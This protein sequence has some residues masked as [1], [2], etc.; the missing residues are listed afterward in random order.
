MGFALAEVANELGAKVTIISG[1]VAIQ[2]HNPNINRIDVISADEMFKVTSENAENQDILIFS[3]AVADYTPKTK[4]EGKL[5]KEY[6]HLD[7]IE[8][9]ET[10]DI[11]KAIAS[12]K[13]ANQTIVGFALESQDLENNA[14]KKLTTKNADYIIA[15]YANKENSGFGGELNTIKIFSKDNSPI[16]LPTMSKYNCALMIFKSIIKK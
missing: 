9:I 15:N 7:K 3:A 14:Q 6:S 10:I 12:Q 8:L 2:N 13:N 16:S 1:P 4:F 5:K 11:L